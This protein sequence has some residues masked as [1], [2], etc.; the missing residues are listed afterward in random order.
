MNIGDKILSLRKKEGLS[1]EM[2]AEK[3]NV[4]R[5]TISKWELNETSPDL[6]QASEISKVFNISLDELVDNDIKNILVEK[7]SNTEKLAGMLIKI[8]KGIGIIILIFI[9]LIIFAMIAFN[10]FRFQGE[11]RTYQTTTINCTLDNKEYTIVVGEKDYFKCDNC[12]SKMRVFIKDITDWANIENSIKNVNT[13]FNERGGNCS[14][15]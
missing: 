11:N 15:E 13:Y 3:L 1:Q 12:D 7:V 9:L 6:K 4:T 14:E 10:V 2:L 5:Q 8:L